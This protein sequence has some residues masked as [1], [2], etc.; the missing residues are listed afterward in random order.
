[1]R[2]RARIAELEAEVAE[3]KEE[4]RTAKDMADV[5]WQLWQ[6]A[7]DRYNATGVELAKLRNEHAI[8]LDHLATRTDEVADLT[9]ELERVAE[10][11]GHLGDLYRLV[12]ADR[13][14]LIAKYVTKVPLRDDR[15]RFLPRPTA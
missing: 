6:N 2:K 14:W 10:L 15:G 7:R 11:H 8:A 9:E 1:M 12:L 5:R 13:D 4:V 3:L